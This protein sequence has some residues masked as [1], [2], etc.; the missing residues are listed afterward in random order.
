MKFIITIFYFLFLFSIA[1]A[2]SSTVLCVLDMEGKSHFATLELVK[3][4]GSGEFQNGVKI[5]VEQNI[6]CASSCSGQ[7]TL[8]IE[9]SSN[10]TLIGRSSYSFFKPTYH[11]QH[12]ALEYPLLEGSRNGNS[13]EVSCSKQ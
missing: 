4:Q 6:I 11:D 3:G 10:E 2:S 1:Q 8:S 7:R 12:G 9:F 5:S 13:F